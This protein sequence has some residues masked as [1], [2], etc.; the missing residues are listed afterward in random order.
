V[1]LLNAS[2]QR[3]AKRLRRVASRL[4]CRTSVQRDVHGVT[5][6]F[7]GVG[8]STPSVTASAGQSSSRNTQDTFDYGPQEIGMSQLQD[9]PSTQQT[10]PR[11]QR[12]R[13]PKKR[14]T[15]GT[16]A[17]GKGKTRSSKQ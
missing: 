1:N 4:G 5:H 10:Q 8:T 12:Q 13:R 16:D 3:V 7:P 17:L 14:Y 9:A 2:I 11:V 6:T 15:P